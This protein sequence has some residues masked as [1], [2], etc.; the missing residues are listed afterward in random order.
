MTAAVDI[1]LG[2]LLGTVE[3]TFLAIAPS[4]ANA[5]SLVLLQK[6]ASEMLRRLLL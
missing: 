2:L 3:A 1:L 5:L 4:F 6:F